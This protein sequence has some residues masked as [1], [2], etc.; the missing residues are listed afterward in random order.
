MN[1]NYEKYFSYFHRSVLSRYRSSP[2]LY[3]LEEDDM[4]GVLNNYGDDKAPEYFEIRFSYRRLS[5]KQICVAAFGPDLQKLPEKEKY[6]WFGEEIENPKFARIDPRFQQV[7]RKI[8]RGILARRR[9]SDSTHQEV[10]RVSPGIDETKITNTV[11]SFRLEY[12][13]PLSNCREH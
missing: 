13:N 6:I 11:I 8:F 9:R 1:K 7:G 3:S 10:Y 12:I 2:N 4:G 5:D